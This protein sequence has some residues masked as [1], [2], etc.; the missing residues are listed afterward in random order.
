MFKKFI[1]FSTALMFVFIFHFEEIP[2][3][4]ETVQ[5]QSDA[6]GPYR[7]LTGTFGNSDIQAGGAEKLRQKTGWIVYTVEQN[8]LRLKTGTFK[9]R[10]AAEK[11]G[12]HIADRF[13][14]TIYVIK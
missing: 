7:L 3:A 2:A 5:S 6:D 11:A 12:Q 10:E 4:A 8:G 14:W 13:G 1:M 9:T